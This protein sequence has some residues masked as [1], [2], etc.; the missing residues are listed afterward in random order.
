VESA[1]LRDELGRERQAR[2][3]AAAE[4][5]AAQRPRA[6][7]P[8]LFLAPERGEGA[9]RSEPTHRLHLPPAGGW[10]VLSLE[11]EPP[12]RRSYEATL[13]D[14]RGRE[15]WHGVGLAPNE[16][17]SLSLG[18]PGALLAPGDFTVTVSATGSR[19][20]PP[21]RFPFRVLATT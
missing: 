15:I 3:E 2:T 11:V 10:V 17:D 8:I 1:Q 16:M 9:G 4:L 6:N 13:R 20:L 14:A 19:A 12:T 21:L 7:L 18:L 5:A